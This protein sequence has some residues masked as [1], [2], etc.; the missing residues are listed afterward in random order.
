M[1]TTSLQTTSISVME[2]KE[3]LINRFLY[4]DDVL[5]E[6]EQTELLLLIGCA[7]NNFQEMEKA[8]LKKFGNLN[9]ILTSSL[10]DLC[11]VDG[12]SENAAAVF[13]VV[14]AC[15]KRSAME[16]VKTKQIS[17]LE[18]WD[19][20]LDYCRQ[21]MAYN[22]IEEFKMFLL[23]EN[24]RYFA[25]KTLSK[26]TVNRTVAHPREI[27][28]TA[29]KC[30]AKNIILAHNHPSGNCKPSDADVILTQDIC[31]VAENAGLSVFDHLI[32][33]SGNIFSFRNEGYLNRFL[34]KTD[35][36]TSK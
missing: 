3:K 4:S 16:A 15:A 10:E 30:N 28:K 14:S 19:L 11:A 29:L 26:G 31:S 33:T 12:I 8:L 32:I 2:S 24:M 34:K 23:D 27:I 35:N 25:D 9:N 18:N 6:E 7:K 5:S 1:K 22:D 21:D 13:K 17:I 20:F 36:K